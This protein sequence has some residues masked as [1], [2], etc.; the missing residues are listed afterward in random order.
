L[1]GQPQPAVSINPQLT[2]APKIWSEAELRDW[3][4]PVAGINMRPSHYSEAEFYAA[5]VDN[6]R[7]YPVYHPDREPPGYL[8]SLRK[9]GAEP[10]LEVGKART[11][12]GWIE[13]G[14]R[15]WEE[16]D[17]LQVRTSDFRLVDYVRSREALKKYPPRMTK[18]GQLFEFRW[19]V[20]KTGELKLSIRECSGCHSQVMADG[21]VISGG[22]GNPTPTAVS[23][24]PTRNCPV[25]PPSINM[26]FSVF[27]IPKA[28]GEALDSPGDGAYA[29]FGVP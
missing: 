8:E 23:D 9:R 2:R 22:Q 10:M 20:D 14:R 13:A 11:R 17:A 28:P 1:T 15:V 21:S 24:C 19:V 26:M 12:E 16:F 6:V 5:P 25:A 18:D 3:F 7:T 29:A 4:N 27:S